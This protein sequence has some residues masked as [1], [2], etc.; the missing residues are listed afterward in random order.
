MRDFLIRI[1]PSR[2]PR[3]SRIPLFIVHGANDTRVPVAQAEEMARRVRA[4]GVP[5]WPTVYTD[6]GHVLRIDDATNNFMLY[7]WIQFMKAYLLN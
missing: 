3:R 4:N 6:E 5:V 2:K 7:T 1:S